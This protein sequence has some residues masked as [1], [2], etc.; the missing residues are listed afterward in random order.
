[1]ESEPRNLSELIERLQVSVD[2][3][4]RVSVGLVVDT[5]GRRSFG[6]L[7][8][9]VGLIILSPLSGIPGAP[10]VL[11]VLVILVAVQMLLGRK[12]FYIPQWLMRRSLDQGTVA[13]AL[14]WSKR[15]A[16]YVDKVLQP[17]LTRLTGH[18]G[19]VVVALVCLLIS[20][21]MP[22]MEFLPFSASAA[23][24]VLTLFGLSLVF[25]DGLLALIA[26]VL[27]GTVGL[28]IWFGF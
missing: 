7:L 24:L 19:S 22:L 12:H 13:R 4:E 3:E 11:S 23:G 27:Y 16:S 8:L 21:S 2:R 9:I 1:M 6:P 20:V 25:R 10:S 17:R 28:S 14:R 5:V 15:P 26:L 18:T